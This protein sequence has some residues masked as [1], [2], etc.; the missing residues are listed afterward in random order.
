VI[1]EDNNSIWLPDFYVW[2]GV[3]KGSLFQGFN[4]ELPLTYN[5]IVTKEFFFQFNID[6]FYYTYNIKYNKNLIL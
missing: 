1:K 6:S 3:G 4:V 2:T 5:I